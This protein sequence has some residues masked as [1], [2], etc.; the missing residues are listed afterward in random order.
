MKLSG[1]RVVDFSQFMP[2][3]MLASNLADHG[4]DVIKVEPLTGDAARGPLESDSEFF[5]GLNRG[6][7]S[8]AL[9]LKRPEGLAIALRLIGEADVVIESSRPGVAARLGI[10]YDTVSRAH[11]RL[12]YCSLT[13]FGQ[14]GPLSQLPAH[15][16]VIQSLAGTLP[17][18]ERGAPVTSGVSV[19]A[20]AGSLTAL[21][22]VLMALLH[23]RETGRGDFVDISLHDAALNAQPHLTG[24]A[25][26]A[27]QED[28]VDTGATAHGGN[29]IALLAA[30]RTADSQWLCLGG[31]EL[32]F[33]T[34]L[35]TPLG[36]PDLIA[37]AIGPGGEAQAELRAFLTEVFLTRTLSDWL[38]WFEG[39]RISVA[40]VL[41]L[42]EALVHP[43]TQ[44]RQMVSVDAAG[45]GHVGNAIR[46][47]R[48]PAQPVLSIPGIG[49]HTV[50]ILEAL[51]YAD[52]HISA[53]DS[54]G[55]IRTQNT[56]E[57][58]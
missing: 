54:A 6:K 15:D 19:A 26:S 45:R 20:L 46:F 3:P 7:R 18:D 12:V 27:R 55:V 33:A 36:R 50:E 25:L 9:D 40:P 47:L 57:K 8:I 44:A 5:V 49:E 34:H 39:R 52:E 21:S 23:A 29:A 43:H 35:L 10:N 17:R 58:A 4:A 30:Y 51:G 16:S 24:H 37:V 56:T 1:V 38:S 14:T 28:F 32:D 48:D 42:S 2:G 22:A 31:R 11:P 53:L 41:S 13:A